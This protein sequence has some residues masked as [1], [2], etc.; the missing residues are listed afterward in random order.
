MKANGCVICGV[1][2]RHAYEM[3][4]GSEHVCIYSELFCIFTSTSITH[5]FISIP[6]LCLT[7]IYYVELYTDVIFLTLLLSGQSVGRQ[8]IPCSL[9][10]LYTKYYTFIV[11]KSNPITGV[12]RP[13]GFQEV[14]APRFQDNRHTKVVSLSTLRT[15]RLYPPGNIPVTHSC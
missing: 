5:R 3:A 13:W 1:K 9:T 11:S 2:C 14:E 12:D 15:G 8:K 6:N 4:W 7:E 10:L